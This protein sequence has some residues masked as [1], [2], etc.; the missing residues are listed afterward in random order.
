MTGLQGIALTSLLIG[1]SGGQLRDPGH[2]FRAGLLN[3]SELA[4]A[5]PEEAPAAA[6]V[7]AAP[8]VRPVP[9]AATVRKQTAARFSEPAGHGAP[10][11]TPRAAS[12]SASAPTAPTASTAPPATAT[13]PRSSATPRPPSPVAPASP[14]DDAAD[15]LRATQRVDAAAALLGT[16]GLAERAFVA[17]VLRAA[18]QDVDVD[19]NASYPAALHEAL[20]ATALQ[21]A[22]AQARPGDLVFFRNTADSNG[23]GKPDDGVTM[24]GI[25]ERVEG[26]RVIFIA[27][28]ANK[29][30]RMAVDPTRPIVVRDARDEVVNTRLVRWPGSQAP[31]T[32]GQCLVGYLRP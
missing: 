25:V 7:A 2:A 4:F 29:V 32:T 28:R 14:R 24:V 27:Q 30:R 10:R 3:E 1:C 8:R 12:T 22:H 18:G 9:H 20:H 6:P 5:S 31:L 26:S 15:A 17:H 19:R 13:A 23:N 16:P 21:V 11:D